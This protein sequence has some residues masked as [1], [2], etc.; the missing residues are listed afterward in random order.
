MAAS[1]DIPIPYPGL[2]P[3][4]EEEAYFFFGQDAQI[5]DL[6]ERLDSNRFVGILGVS[7]CGKSS[8]LY[9]GLL[10]DVRPKKIEGGRPRW[11]IG[12]MKPGGD[13]L[14]ALVDTVN[15]LDR[16]F[17]ESKSAPD[18]RP[19]FDPEAF[20]ADNSGLARFGSEAKLHEE[21]RILVVVDQFEELFR[22][23]RDATTTVQKDRAAQFVQ[24][25]LGA[26]KEEASLV[27]VVITMR[28]EFLGDC[29]LFFGL[30]E[31]INQGTFL[32]SKMTRDQIE[33]VVVGPSDE[34]GFTID[35]AVVQDLLNETE[36]QEDG[37]PLL[38]HALRRIWERW[39]ARGATGAISIDDFHS[40]EVPPPKGTLLIK[41]H[42][43]DH[44]NSIYNSLGSRKKIAKLFF[45]L[46]SERDPR[47]RVTRRPVPFADIVAAIG[48]DR[49][50]DINAVIDAFRNE[51]EG[52]T[53][54]TPGWGKNT[55]GAVIDISHECLL[56]RWGRLGKWIALEQDD[57]DQF[58]RLADDADQADLRARKKGEARKPIEGANLDT[59]D[60]WWNKSKLI[61][62]GWALRYQGEM[63]KELSRPARS[64]AAAREYLE[65]SVKEARRKAAQRRAEE[66]A[67]IIAVERAQRAETEARLVQA[68]AARKVAEAAR[69]SIWQRVLISLIGL[70]ALCLL[71]G[72]SA[73]R[74]ARSQRAAAKADY[75]RLTANVAS[76]TKLKELADKSTNEQRAL[77][78]QLTD[79]NGALKIA[80]GSLASKNAQLTEAV[81]EL[82][83]N[84]KELEGANALLKT[85]EATAVDLKNKAVA[86]TEEANRAKTVA[87]KSASELADR[88]RRD[89]WQADLAKAQA[90]ISA[91]Y[92]SLSTKYRVTMVAESLKNLDHAAAASRLPAPLDKLDE[93]RK[94]GLQALDDAILRSLVKVEQNF[95]QADGLCYQEDSG[96]VLSIRAPVLLWYNNGLQGTSMLGRPG[97]GGTIQ[98]KLDTRLDGDDPFRLTLSFLSHRL[99]QDQPKVA[100]LSDDCQTAM[101][102]SESGTVFHYDTSLV[103]LSRLYPTKPSVPAQLIWNAKF[104]P[105]LPDRKKVELVVSSPDGRFAFAALAARGWAAW[106]LPERRPIIHDQD[107]RITVTSA[108]FSPD[109]RW[110]LVQVNSI[111]YLYDLEAP[112]KERQGITSFVSGTTVP[113]QISVG[114]GEQCVWFSSGGSFVD[115]RP[116]LNVYHGTSELSAILLSPDG[117]LLSA[118]RADG[119]V[120]VWMIGKPSEKPTHLTDPS[121]PPSRVSRLSWSK[122]ASYLTVLHENGAVRVWQLNG[123]NGRTT[124]QAIRDLLHRVEVEAAS[125]KPGDTG[126][127]VKEAQELGVP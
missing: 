123:Q 93:T 119:S 104:V 67:A 127:L 15:G 70:A 110:L 82:K 75:E 3:F 89:Q 8:L 52:R 43:D 17:Q 55:E 113:Q 59:F 63:I 37:L 112:N 95:G 56:R 121:H 48:S 79:A 118:G 34:A 5:A 12:C 10:A 108:S 72:V 16:Q 32:L 88:Q 29:S 86:A 76:Q 33:E 20:L 85:Q 21:Q 69:R 107:Q 23:Q 99:I 68:E 54:L 22:Y 18:D 35:P 116:R 50:A 47:G 124:S 71:G 39:R 65:W 53:F 11:F 7:G 111:V 6:R 78:K 30:A 73:Y 114:S 84:S 41:H 28:S 100:A 102:G 125:A 94:A 96:L 58:R 103:N 87:E 77:V 117:T 19:P 57:A 80:E 27:S 49:V 101:I 115:S 26:A 2:R 126:P 46:L 92:R 109:G 13:P 122:S 106:K 105:P 83:A 120:D 42:L 40:C 91:S 97:T 9:A 36:Q 74:I 45:R 64:F 66:E 51:K 98:M 4:R 25:L 44:L 81:N 24:L 62:A 14:G 1:L 38:Q 31:Q 90:G 60:R 61:G